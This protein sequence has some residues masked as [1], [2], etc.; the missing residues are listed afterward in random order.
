MPA[1]Q[2]LA[3]VEARTCDYAPNTVTPTS[4]APDEDEAGDEA[5]ADAP[6]AAQGEDTPLEPLAAEA[7]RSEGTAPAA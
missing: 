2:E 5:A 7:Y 6:V 1:H 4:A 3:K